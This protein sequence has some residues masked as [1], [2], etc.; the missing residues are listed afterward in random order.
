MKLINDNGPFYDS[1]TCKITSMI[2]Q[3]IEKC[4]LVVY[5]LKIL[6]RY[7]MYTYDIKRDY[8]FIISKV[9]LLKLIAL[10]TTNDSTNN[11]EKTLI[12]I[13]P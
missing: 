11:M 7:S 13:R 3:L 1:Q 9:H 2:E 8:L 10:K 12:F 4:I 5:P 6:K